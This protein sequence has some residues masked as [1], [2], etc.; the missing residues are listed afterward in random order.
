MY[1]AGTSIEDCITQFD[2]ATAGRSPKV[3]RFS[4]SDASDEESSSRWN[5]PLRK[6]AFKRRD[7]LK[8]I[9]G[10]RSLL[11]CGGKSTKVAVAAVKCKDH[12]ICIFTNYNGPEIS[13]KGYNLIRS[14]N[15]KEEM[16]AWQV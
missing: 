12:S 13:R 6:I 2:S 9:L 8:E 4:E 10:K 16:P 1:S 14:E 3:S 7:A 5:L 11:E 15:P